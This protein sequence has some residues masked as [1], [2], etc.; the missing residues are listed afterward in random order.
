MLK[1]KVYFQL[2]ALVQFQ[3]NKISK[4]IENFLRIDRNTDTFEMTQG[5]QGSGTGTDQQVVFKYLSYEE[6]ITITQDN[7]RTKFSVKA[8]KIAN[9]LK[10]I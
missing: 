9:Q 4:F 10:E 1:Q 5:L 2:Q 7:F 8:L 6:D 3:T